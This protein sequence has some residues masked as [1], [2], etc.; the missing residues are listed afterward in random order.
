MLLYSTFG[1]FLLRKDMVFGTFPSIDS[2]R[3]FPRV[4]H[5]VGQALLTELVKAQHKIDAITA[6]ENFILGFRLGV[7]LMAECMDDND[8]DI[9]NGGG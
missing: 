8:G 7:R 4:G 5:G 1:A 3:F 2:V 6:T 9:R